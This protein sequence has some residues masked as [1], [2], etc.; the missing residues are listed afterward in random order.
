MNHSTYKYL[1][2]PGHGRRACSRESILCIYLFPPIADVDPLPSEDVA[3]HDQQ[4]QE[5]Q[6]Q[7]NGHNDGTHAFTQIGIN[8]TNEVGQV[9]VLDGR[10]VVLDVSIV[11]YVISATSFM[12]PL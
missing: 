10:F 4:Q 12:C 7:R 8:V 1:P 6:P 2:I 9:H 5:Q 3:Q 11:S